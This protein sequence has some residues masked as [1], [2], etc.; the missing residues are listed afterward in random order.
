[1]LKKYF[2][3]PLIA[4]H[5]IMSC[6]SPRLALREWTDLPREHYTI[7]PYAQ[8]LAPFKIALDPGHGGLSHLPGYKRGPSGKEE[9]VMNLNVA[10]ALKEF[11]E[12][13]GATVVLTRSD[14]RFV[15]LQERATIAERA[16]CDFMISLHH[17]AAENPQVNYASVYYHLYPDYSPASMDLGRHIYFGLVEALRLP[18]VANEGLLSDKMI[19]PDGFGLL[20][21][22]RMPAVL[23]ESS[24]FSNPRE[25]KR[26]TNLRYNRRE[27]YGIFL[28]LARWAASGIPRAQLVQ[29]KAISRDKKPEIVYQLFDGIT[30]RGGR[31]VG[32][33]LAYAQSASLKIDSQPVPAQID[34]KKKRL[35]FQPDSSLRNGKHL[36]QVD[37]QNLFK[38]HNL[39]RVDTLIIAAPT[40]FIAF[41][42]PASKLPADGVAAMPITLTLCDAENEPVWEGTSVIVQADKGRIISEP[43]SLQDGRAT[44][45]YQAGTEPGPVNLFASADSHSDTLQLELTPPGDF[46]VLSGMAV[47]DSTGKAVAGAELALND[48]VWAQTDGAGGFFIARPPAGLHRFEMRAAGYAPATE[49]ITIDSMQ[50][51]FRRSVLHANLNGLLHE[52]TIILDASFGG[53]ETGDRFDEGLTAADANFALMSHL[54]DSLKWAGAQA[55]LLRQASDTDLPVSAR[56]AAANQIPQGWYLKC[57]YRKWNSDSLLVQTTI[58]PGNQMGESIAIALNQAFAKRPNTRTVLRRNTDVPEVTRTNKTAVGV[59]LSCRRPELLER[60]LPALFRGI[61]DFYLA[62]SRT[63]GIPE[64]Q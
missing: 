4:S 37:L 24:F 38:N 20:R 21:A 32:Q 29:P 3:L 10:F 28:G 47:D 2:F 25:E 41:E 58:Y 51:V 62:Q 31:G 9:A 49:M 15:S 45:Y 36:L 16:A 40:R 8:H 35:W 59:T 54:A 44:F 11:L 17:N 22:A 34:L 53:A 48:S 56:I 63:S 23:L 61:V 50:S 30:E 18:Q 46:W 26:L 14:D 33:L 39:P 6:G 42:T 1:M 27:A 7:P 43:N 64:E 12:A 13:A 57:D 19:Y 52:Q 55:I 5:L 60:D